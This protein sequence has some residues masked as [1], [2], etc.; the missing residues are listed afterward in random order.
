M[1][2]IVIVSHSEKLAEGVFDVTKIM[3]EGCPVAIAGGN[4][5]GGNTGGGDIPIIE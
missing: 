5:D 1:V 4:D 3:A 2:G